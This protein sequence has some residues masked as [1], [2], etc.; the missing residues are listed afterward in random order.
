MTYEFA[1]LAEVLSDH[2]L[3]FQLHRLGEIG[4]DLKS[5]TVLGYNKKV[6]CLA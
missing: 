6:T 5:D 1:E 4:E 2:R 3:Y